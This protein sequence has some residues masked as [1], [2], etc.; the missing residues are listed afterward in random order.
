MWSYQNEVSLNR[1]HFTAPITLA[2]FQVLQ[3]HVV[4]GHHTEE[5]NSLLQ[6]I[7]TH[8]ETSK[9]YIIGKVKTKSY[10][11][12]LIL[13]SLKQPLGTILLVIVPCVIIIVLEIIKIISVIG[14]NKKNKEQLEIEELKKKLAVLE[15]QQ[16]INNNV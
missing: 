13:Y 15:E 6:I 2:V 12:G 5:S 9:N 4:R 16:Q 1:K 14:T 3:H 10:L 11:F 8:D 7:D